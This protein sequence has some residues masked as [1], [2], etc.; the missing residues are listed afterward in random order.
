MTTFGRA[1]A[2]AYPPPVRRRWGSELATEIDARGRPARLDALAGAARLWLRPGEWPAELGS[3][4]R[5][6]VMGLALATAAVAGLGF[7]GLL[8]V[9]LEGAAAVTIVGLVL[10]G[11]GLAVATPVVRPTRQ[12]V[13]ALLRP[14]R[15]LV[16]LATALVLLVLS[17]AYGTTP[18]GGVLHA[19]EFALYWATLGLVAFLP[20]VAIAR[21]DPAMLIVPGRARAGVGLGLVSAGQLVDAGSGLLGAGPT[22]GPV[23]AVG[24]AA[25]G[26]IT[27]LALVD[28]RR[29]RAPADARDAH[30]R[31]DRP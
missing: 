12:A 17:L 31:P 18:T 30:R 24:Q 23:L 21:A 5:R 22:G 28:L 13:A 11:A 3:Q 26:V 15:R 25:L 1:V 27:L 9:P 10:L 14:V 16:V 8:S 2:A 19:G 6:A 20:V 4:V 7:R 29:H